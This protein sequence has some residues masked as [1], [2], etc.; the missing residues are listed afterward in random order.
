MNDRFKKIMIVFMIGFATTAMYSLPYMKSVFYD[1]MR[2]AL[3][4][5]HKQLGNLLS[6]YGI[7][8]TVSYFSSGGLALLTSL[9]LKSLVFFFFTDIYGNFGG[10]CGWQNGT[11]LSYTM[12]WIFFPFWNNLSILYLFSLQ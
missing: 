6:I 5:N 11:M 3:S 9:Q 2:E 12:I 10:E 8:A 4:L 7:V 1:P